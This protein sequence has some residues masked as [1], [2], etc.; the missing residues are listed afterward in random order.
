[1]KRIIV[2]IVACFLLFW[3]VRI[4]SI[5]QNPPVTTY[6]DIG[7]SI[8][9]GDMEVNF[10]ESHLEDPEQF[11][12]RFGFE[13]DDSDGECKI[14]SFCI[15]VTNKSDKGADL[16]DVIERFACGFEGPRWYNA[17]NP[18]VSHRINRRDEEILSSG[19]TRKIW[20]VT[21]I[22][23]KC[24]RKSTWKHIDEYQY[25]FVVAFFPQKIAVRLNK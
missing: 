23:M 18:E 15:S 5:N 25:D 21:E 2:V 10:V 9:F 8:D 24:F 16:S 11:K 7:D 4:I 12:E 1:M 3:T 13:A 6:Y 20:Y 19:E 14:I 17:I 22:P